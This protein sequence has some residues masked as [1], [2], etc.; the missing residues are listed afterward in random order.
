MRRFRILPSVL[1]QTIKRQAA[2]KSVLIF[3]LLTMLF[4]VGW[5]SAAQAQGDI[6]RKVHP[7]HP[8]LI[9]TQAGWDKLRDE[10]LARQIKLGVVPADTK[11]A[12]KPETI[13]D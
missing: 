4:S 7:E 8:R 3:L 9:F 10:T 5:P 6:V 12:P 11:L 2:S 1:G 13:K